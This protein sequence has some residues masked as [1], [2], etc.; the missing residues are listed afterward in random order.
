MY[1]VLQVEFCLVF[2]VVAIV[3]WTKRV[4]FREHFWWLILF[5]SIGIILDHRIRGVFA[6]E[7]LCTTLCFHKLKHDF[8]WLFK[9]LLAL[10]LSSHIFS[11]FEVS[12]KRISWKYFTFR[13]LYFHSGSNYNL[14]TFYGCQ[15]Q[16]GVQVV[17]HM[18]CFQWS[19]I[20]LHTSTIPSGLVFTL[21]KLC[22]SRMNTQCCQNLFETF[23]LQNISI[24]S[25]C[26]DDF[27]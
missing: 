7:M 14:S 26:N 18:L 20:I 21:P 1:N 9:F 8:I 24:C 19:S 2:H 17:S 16:Y 12:K 15:N 4:N 6:L 23:T 22:V 3:S 27:T 5:G 13:L 25:H 10:S 11:L